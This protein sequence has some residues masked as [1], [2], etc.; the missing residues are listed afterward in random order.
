MR[1]VDPV[2]AP[3][4]R[5]RFVVRVALAV[6]VLV[7][8]SAGCEG[9]GRAGGSKGDASAGSPPRAPGLQSSTSAGENALRG[10]ATSSPG[11]ASIACP[12]VAPPDAAT[13]NWRLVVNAAD[14]LLPNGRPR[15][16]GLGLAMPPAEAS[17]AIE[18]GARAEDSLVLRATPSEQASSVAS[19]VVRSVMDRGIRTTCRGFREVAD[20]AL[21]HRPNLYASGVESL[22][23][24]PVDS[25]TPDSAWL[26]AAYAIDTTFAVR[27]GWI[28][29]TGSRPFVSWLALFNRAAG[30]AVVTF[31]DAAMR[32]PSAEAFR[33][34]PGGPPARVQLPRAPS[35][36]SMYLLR[37]EGTWGEVRLELGDPCG[38]GP[39]TTLPGTAWVR[40]VDDRGRPLVLLPNEGVC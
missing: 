32:A 18:Q 4:A 17:G 19:Y 16:L 1:F 30:D 6:A 11:D 38:E 39:I 3:W 34:A 27:R 25:I 22:Q 5:S 14:H 35:D 40:L 29:V 20:R 33:S 36:W 37:V 8:V 13:I 15:D 21:Q 10:G 23:G 9:T 2:T 12:V 24:F 7:A 26:R 28:H 31:R